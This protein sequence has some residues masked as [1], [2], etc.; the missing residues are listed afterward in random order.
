MQLLCMVQKVQG[1]VANSI[2]NN[3]N[4]VHYNVQNN[5]MQGYN[6]GMRSF[7]T[8]NIYWEHPSLHLSLV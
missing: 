6:K 4:S 1:K 5:S 2:T 8:L 3:T 7:A